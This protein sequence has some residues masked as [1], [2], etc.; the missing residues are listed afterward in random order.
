MMPGQ[1]HLGID[2]GT[3]YTVAA[4]AS[5][6][7]VSVL[8]IESNGQTRMPSSVFLT[9]TGEILVGSAAQHQAVFAPE[10]FEP[11]PK[12]C[13]TDG[14]IFLGDDLIPVVSLVSGVLRK[15]FTEACRQRGET[16]P[17]VV[18]LTH[19]AEWGQARLNLLREAAQG[20]GLPEVVLVPE[21]VAAAVWIAGA[22]T[23]PGDLI[24]VY[25]FGGGTFD[26]AVLRRAGDAF[27]VA[28][29]PAGRDP[30][31]GEDIDRHVL[32]YIGRVVAA[33][34]PEQWQSLI[35]PPDITWRRRSA[36][37]RME[38]Q[39]AKETLSEVNACQLWLPGL[40]RE[41]Q[42]TRGELEE[43]I[44]ADLDLCTDTLLTALN[45]AS[46]TPEQLHG[47]YLVGGS[48]RIPLV[49][50]TL[51]RRLGVRPSVQD[52]PKSV[53]ALGAARWTT[54]SSS[55]SAPAPSERS[56]VTIEDAPAELVIERTDQQGRVYVPPVLAVTLPPEIAGWRDS[57]SAYL[58]L[59]RFVGSPATIRLREQSCPQLGV[60]ELAARVGA[61]RA[62]RS[63]DYVEVAVRAAS[64]FGWPGLERHFVITSRG[65]RVPMVERYVV[66]ADR[67]IVMA[68]P[69]EVAGIADAVFLAEAWPSAGPGFSS[70]VVL[71]RPPGWR[72]TEELRLTGAGAMTVLSAERSELPDEPTEAWR[73]HRLESLLREL[74]DA[75]GAGR[76]AG[77][78]LGR[79]PGEIVT[80]RWRGPHLP[81]VTKLGMAPVSGHGFVLS[82]NLPVQDQ[83]D[84]RGLAGLA[85]LRPELTS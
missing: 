11:T 83:G 71:P 56:V 31:G 33:E 79:L 42:L 58:T 57:L 8:E 61:F 3:S 22:A 23:T 16:L 67:S 34:S 1:W 10:R 69:G 18:R 44:T 62:T 68:Y 70:P 73:W 51:W 49:A 46:V 32:E 84:F 77:R 39:R 64:V 25:D 21:P 24:A 19:P 20:A 43:L 60:T 53:V 48:S 29:P 6:A 65:L 5:D 75:A 52:S 63:R 4:I 28:G 26:A 74:P 80:I 14:E 37:F 72:T 15:V 54:S 85:G 82:V 78:A 7:G 59:D 17:E 12:R 13:L 30:L 41:L 76:T 2:F 66:V 55:V 81:M 40:E 36:A 50:Q 35:D 45:D 38:V 9:E 47:L 27:E